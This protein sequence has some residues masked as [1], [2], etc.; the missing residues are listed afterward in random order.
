MS[1]IVYGPGIGVKWM[2]NPV[3]LEPGTPSHMDLSPSFI[4]SRVRG[5]G[6]I[7]SVL[8]VC[9]FGFAM[10][11]GVIWRYA[12]T[13]SC[14]VVSHGIMNIWSYQ[15]FLGKNTDKEGTMQ[16]GASMLR[17]F[18]LSKHASFFPTKICWVSRYDNALE[19]LTLYEFVFAHVLCFL[20]CHKS[21]ALKLTLLDVESLL[22]LLLQ[23]TLQ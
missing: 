18:H 13:S 17:R 7:L 9:V 12:V 16:E 19:A 3:D 20:F 23:V 5:W 2:Y 1:L 21:D 11:D 22:L 6:Y 15:L 10:A 14:R 8:P 4:P